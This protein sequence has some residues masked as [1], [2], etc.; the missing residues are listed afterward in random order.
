MK[1]IKKENNFS[2]LWT[3]FIIYIV[4]KMIFISYKYI[5]RNNSF[6]TKNY[7]LH[8]MPEW[9][10]ALVE[11]VQKES[12]EICT[13]PTPEEKASG[14][15]QKCWKPNRQLTVTKEKNE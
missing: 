2:W 8:E 9:F 7:E 4:F 5:D 1:S 11:K 13:N 15:Q 6:G 3:L 12:R 10:P 14:V